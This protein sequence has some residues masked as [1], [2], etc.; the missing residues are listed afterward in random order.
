MRDPDRPATL[1]RPILTDLLRVELGFDGLIVTDAIEMQAVA[2]RYGLAGA[3][4]AALAAGGACGSGRSMRPA[5]SSRAAP[6]R[7]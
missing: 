3:T 2:R 1:S 6:Q 4:V 7:V 5:R